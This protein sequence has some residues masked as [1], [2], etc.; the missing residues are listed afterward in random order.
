MSMLMSLTEAG[1]QLITDPTVISASS[2]GGILDW[3]DNKASQATNTIRGVT[4]LLA[5]LFVVVAAVMSRMSMARVLIAGIAAGLFIW[6]VFNVTSIQDRVDSEI[7]ASGAVT[8]ST[9]SG[10]VAGPAGGPLVDI[11]DQRS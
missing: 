9:V 2:S 6:I 4:V 8:G 3:V 11:T 7:N 1:T 5:I 10:P